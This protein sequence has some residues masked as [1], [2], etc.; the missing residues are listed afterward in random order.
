[1]EW[2]L[3]LGA[4]INALNN[5]DATPLHTAAANG[6]AMSVEWLL[7]HVSQTRHGPAR[8]ACMHVGHA[9][10]WGMLHLACCTCPCYTWQAV[11]FC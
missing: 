11:A 9:C 3:T 5:S 6:Q 4:D 1:M 8:G 2:L 7:A 10:T